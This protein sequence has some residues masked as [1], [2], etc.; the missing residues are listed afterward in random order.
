M[1]KDVELLSVFQPFEF[2]LLRILC[3]DPYPIYLFIWLVGWVLVFQDRVSLCSCGCPGSYS[4]NL[5][6]LELTEICLCLPS[7]YWD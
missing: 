5:A 7:K 4:V 1:A 2:P 6:G 3:I